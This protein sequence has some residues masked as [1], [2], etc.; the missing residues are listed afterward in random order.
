MYI[1]GVILF[2]LLIVLSTCV[3]VIYLGWYSWKHIKLDVEKEA[4][5][6]DQIDRDSGKKI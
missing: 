5:R 1:D 4:R 3:V 2:G 6:N